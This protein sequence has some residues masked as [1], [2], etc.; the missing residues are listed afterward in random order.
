MCLYRT[1]SQ[2]TNVCLLLADIQAKYR[3]NAS[4][5]PSAIS[6]INSEDVNTRAISQ[7]NGFQDYDA[8]FN[9]MFSGPVANP[10]QGT[11]IG[12]FYGLPSYYHNDTVV[13]QFENDT[14]RILPNYA[15]MSSKTVLDFSSGRELFE[16]YLLNTPQP[17]NASSTP[18]TPT[19]TPQPKP[20]P[21]VPGYPVPVPGTKHPKDLVSGYFFKEAG[22][23][24]LAVLAIPSFDAETG[25]DQIDFQNGVQTFL[26]ACRTSGKQRLIIDVRQNPGGTIAV[27]YDTFKQLFPS[28]VPYSGMRIRA[29]DAADVIGLGDSKYISLIEQTHDI[30]QLIPKYEGKGWDPFFNGGY[31]ESPDSHVFPSWTDFYGPVQSHGDNF[32]HVGSWPF[33]SQIYTGSIVVSGYGNRSHL[34]PQAFTSSNIILVS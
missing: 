12:G 23:S 28:V 1:S 8:L 25:Q 7:P 31:L 22:Y 33:S 19:P 18:S 2:S 14:K 15:W 34:P 6:T 5:T 21:T 10:G 24:D 17:S 13:Y 27:G 32:T 30:A 11:T 29:H 26:A 3:W 16:K 4:F 9:S 20:K